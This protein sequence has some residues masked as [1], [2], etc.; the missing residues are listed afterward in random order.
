MYIDPILE[1]RKFIEPRVKLNSNNRLFI[2]RS[3]AGYRRASNEYDAFLAVERFGFKLIYLED[4]QFEEQVSLFYGAQV[5]VGLHGAGFSNIIFCRDKISVVEI[6][7]NQT[8]Q[9]KYFRNLCS[10]LDFNYL[11]TDAQGGFYASDLLIDIDA[12]VKAVSS[13]FP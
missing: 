9:L 2:S 3:K 10:G 5:V 13:F 11:Q 1:L 7:P 4:L 6:M 8:Y 12:F